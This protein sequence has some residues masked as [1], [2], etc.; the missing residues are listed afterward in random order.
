MKKKKKIPIRKFY[1]TVRLFVS[2]AVKITFVC[3]PMTPKGLTIVK[4]M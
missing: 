2:K 1:N 3:C 4:F